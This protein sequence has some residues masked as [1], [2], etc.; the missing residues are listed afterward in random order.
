MAA[1]HVSPYGVAVRSAAS[2]TSGGARPHAAFAVMTA[3]P[4]SRLSEGAPPVVFRL[5][6]LLAAEAPLEDFHALLADP[7]LTSAAGDAQPLREAVRDLAD[8]VRAAE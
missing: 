7:V 6:A 8:A 5:L 4:L 2:A 1:A 3:E